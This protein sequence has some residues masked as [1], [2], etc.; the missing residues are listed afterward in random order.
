VEVVDAGT[1]LAEL[2]LRER[3]GSMS[4]VDLV[5]SVVL[6]T[7]ALAVAGLYLTRSGRGSIKS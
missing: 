3:G 5:V 4:F 7:I 1:L 6:T 2:D